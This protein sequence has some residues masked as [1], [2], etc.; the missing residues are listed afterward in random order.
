MDFDKLQALQGRLRRKFDLVEGC[1]TQLPG[2]E[3]GFRAAM[4][5]LGSFLLAEPGLREHLWQLNTMTPDFGPDYQDLLR[6]GVMPIFGAVTPSTEELTAYD[7]ASRLFVKVRWRKWSAPTVA[8]AA[9]A[10]QAFAFRVLQHCYNDPQ[11]ALNIGR[12][13]TELNSDKERFLA[14][15]RTFLHPLRDV[16]QDILEQ[17]DAAFGLL[18]KYK[19]SVEFDSALLRRRAS[20]RQP[21]VTEEDAYANHLYQYLHD[22]DFEVSVE[23]KGVSRGRP[24][25]VARRFALDVKVFDGA[26][27]SVAYIKQG[28]RQVY[29]YL[30]DFNKP[31]GYV[32]VF[33]TC[34]ADLHLDPCPRDGSYVQIQ[35]KTIYLVVIDIHPRK[36]PPSKAPLL[37]KKL[38][39]EDIVKDALAP[40]RPPRVKAKRPTRTVQS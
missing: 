14:F 20:T 10:G 38:L 8:P 11:D 24:D 13:L 2:F 17:R 9:K 28:F 1:S 40:P 32:V 25:A 33:R 26:K 27:R 15:C 35:G 37:A 5:T 21:G 18:L 16:M 4:D 19:K 7:P 34:G 39:V 31:E 12:H 22:H 3:G 29:Q 36:K 6:D 30:R 23:P